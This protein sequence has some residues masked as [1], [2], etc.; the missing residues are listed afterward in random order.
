M[1]VQLRDEDRIGILEIAAQLAGRINDNT[2]TLDKI[3]GKEM[4]TVKIVNPGILL[5]KAITETLEN[6]FSHMQRNSLDHG[7]EKA[8]ERIQTGKDPVGEISVALSHGIGKY[9][10]PGYQFQKA[11]NNGS[12]P[13][14]VRR[15]IFIA[16][17]PERRPLNNKTSVSS[18]QE[19]VP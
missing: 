7:I 6:V 2:R 18:S 5:S 13:S 19:N 11:V 14:Y 8:S 10:L 17:S 15:P 3:L 1:A 4:P 16:S 12:S 9:Q